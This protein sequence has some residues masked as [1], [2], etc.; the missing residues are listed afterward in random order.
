MWVTRALKIV[1]F[2]DLDWAVFRLFVTV[3]P[4]QMGL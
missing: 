3:W 1:G 2:G 4:Y